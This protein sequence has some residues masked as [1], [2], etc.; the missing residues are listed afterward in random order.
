MSGGRIFGWDKVAWDQGWIAGQLR[1]ENS[2][3]ASVSSTQSEMR[4]TLARIKHVGDTD[5][6][7][8]DARLR[9]ECHAERR[10]RQWPQQDRGRLA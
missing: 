7:L 1:W 9:A 5:P 10:L 8:I 4:E 6:G 2:I 3:E